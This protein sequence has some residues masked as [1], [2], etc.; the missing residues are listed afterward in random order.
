[1]ILLFQL[2]SFAELQTIISLWDCVCIVM[3]KFWYFILHRNET[4]K[5]HS[6]RIMHCELNILWNIS[7]FCTTIVKHVSYNIFSSCGQALLCIR[8][9]LYILYI[10]IIALPIDIKIWTGLQWFLLY[11]RSY[12]ENFLVDG[13]CG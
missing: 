9:L 11:F 4:G 6:S 7:I 12:L 10:L 1:M 13:E 2:L 3:Y 5:M 8:Y